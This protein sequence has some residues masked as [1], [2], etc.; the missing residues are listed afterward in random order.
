MGLIWIN[1]IF[2]VLTDPVMQHYS[3]MFLFQ[4]SSTNIWLSLEGYSLNRLSG[5][6]QMQAQI[7]IA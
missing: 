4:N 5:N 7:K 6:T 2:Y 1:T 3:M